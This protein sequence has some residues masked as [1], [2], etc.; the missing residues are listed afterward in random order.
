MPLLDPLF[1]A[2]PLGYVERLELRG[3]YVRIVGW[4]RATVVEA[5]NGIDTR[6]GRPFLPRG[7]VGLNSDGSPELAGY[8]LD[9]PYR[10]QHVVVT[11]RSSNQA[12]HAVVRTFSRWSTS[13]AMLAA[14]A[15]YLGALA[16]VSPAL[17]RW[18]VFRRLTDR[19]AVM[20]RLGVAS[21]AHTRPVALRIRDDVLSPSEHGRRA[22]K[23]SRFT[24]V[25][26]VYNAFDLLVEC[27]D[28][29][30][31]N[32][33][34]PYDI[35][36]IDDKSTDS[37]ILPHLKSWIKNAHV[38][39]DAVLIENENNYG[40]IESV[41]R[42]LRA[43]RVKSSH[44]VLLNTDA[45]VPPGWASRLL[46]PIYIDARVATVTPMSNDAEIFSVPV[47]CRRSVLPSGRADLIDNRARQL[48][49]AAT[50]SEVPTGVGFCMAMNANFLRRVGDLDL[51]FGRGYGEEVDWCQRAQQ[52]GGINVGIG[53]LFVEHRGGES[54]GSDEKEKLV[55]EHNAI[56]SAKYP[57][58]DRQVQE[59]IARDELVTSR[60]ALALAGASAGELSIFLAHSLG[61]GA[62]KYLQ[63]RI[64][65][66]LERGCPAVVLRVGSL[67]GRWVVE[68]FSGE[69]C[70]SAATNNWN[71]V[72]A[73]L[74]PIGCRHIIYSCAV[75]DRN[76]IEIPS[77][78]K[79][80]KRGEHD[81]I[82]LLFHDFF[83]L[84]P[85]YNLLGDDG[86]FAGVP[87]LGNRDL[88]HTS[89]TDA[90]TLVSLE[91]WRNS[92]KS[93][94]HSADELV[95]F[96]ED[97]AQHVIHAWRDLADRVKV[98]P[99]SLLSPIK[100]LSVSRGERRTLAVLGNINYAK[101]AAVVQSL[102]HIIN[103]IEG[104]ERLIIVGNIDPDYII[105]KT[106]IIHGDY[107]L[108]DIED[109]VFKYDITDW[110]IPSI[111]PETFSYTTHEALA[112]GLLVWGF[113]VGAQAKAL[114]AAPNGRLVS[115]P[116]GEW[117][118]AHLAGSL[119]TAI[120][121]EHAEAVRSD[122]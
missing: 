3:S 43:A 4:S 57:S 27:L 17:V 42:G 53:N 1:G 44:I 28:R 79:E 5:S 77:L 95:V 105:P 81:K 14:I 80:L 11:V 102:A 112:T 73:L 29:V 59:F 69:G 67:F 61:G 40:F 13:A 2:V 122:K 76:P 9:L 16:F 108:S 90:G 85:S 51:A 78:L 39:I 87:D 68:F 26:P 107:I 31:G 66:L 109:I 48:S 38:D 83:P 82:E 115:F 92:W 60:L 47:I 71:T 114:K 55:Q 36:I 121:S 12:A 118:A 21:S 58:Y 30:R 111:W 89:R 70:T 6:R 7:D 75:G 103:E 104:M 19:D 8:E 50:I 23:F 86:R 54:F 62:E 96:S 97:S 20:G 93:L 34:I 46:A 117:T 106:S 32:T 22:F 98:R 37:R 113:D 88:V 24:I 101:G 45:L 56:I 91:Q 120:R 49:G 41:N 18:L 25:I 84:S 72:Q 100:E 10:G 119:I 116:S 74:E 94:A 63:S 99:H 33:D 35:I 52:L 15:G 64:A 110:I 65:S